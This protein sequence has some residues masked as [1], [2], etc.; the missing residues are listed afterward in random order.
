MVLISFWH[1]FNQ[2]TPIHPKP[3]EF[4]LLKCHGELKGLDCAFGYS[5]TVGINSVDSPVGG[6]KI[7]ESQ[8][9]TESMEIHEILPV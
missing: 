5:P 2:A 3:P 6:N 4:V 1:I 9:S 8:N 7:T